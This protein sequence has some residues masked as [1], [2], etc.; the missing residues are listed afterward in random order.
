MSNENKTKKSIKELSKIIKCF[1]LIIIFAIIFYSGTLF[2]S[3]IINQNKTTKLGFENIGELVT[4]KCNLSI[5]GDIKE[6]KELF[7]VKIPFTESR[8]IF[9]YNISVD[10]S[11]D[12]AKIKIKI[13]NDKKQII[14]EI[15]HAKVYSATIDD[16][17]LKVYIDDESLFTRIDLQEHNDERIKLKEQGIEDAKANGLL[18]LAEENAERLIQGFIKQNSLYKDYTI[19]FEY[20]NKD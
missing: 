2:K 9:S 16:E 17:S 4:Q 5:I 6:H 10:A 11:I 12:F 1:I 15:P 14:V 8:Q 19:L 7:N 13:N 18:K 20:I 3:V